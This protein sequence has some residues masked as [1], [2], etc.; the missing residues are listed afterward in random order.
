MTG[1][2]RPADERR[3]KN[4]GTENAVYKELSCNH[5]RV[6]KRIPGKSGGEYLQTEY[7]KN[8]DEYLVSGAQLRCSMATSKKMTI[9]GGLMFRKTL[10][11]QLTLNAKK[12]EWKAEKAR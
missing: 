9:E 1:K 4:G 12:I 7:L 8:E 11:R 6:G 10:R 5:E 2:T 3:K